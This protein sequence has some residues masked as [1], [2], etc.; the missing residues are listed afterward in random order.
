MNT[1]ITPPRMPII[2]AG[3]AIIRRILDLRFRASK[4]KAN[5]Q[6]ARATIAAAIFAGRIMMSP[7]LY[8][9]P[10]LGQRPRRNVYVR[11]APAPAQIPP[12]TPNFPT[13]VDAPMLWHIFCRF[14]WS[15]QTAVGRTVHLGRML[16]NVPS[17]QSSGRPS[18]E[19]TPAHRATQK[20]GNVGLIRPS[21][22]FRFAA[23]NGN[24]PTSE[25]FKA[26]S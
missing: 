17:S 9:T 1:E 12:P 22:R 6:N 25:F 7:F 10:E 24:D 19:A 11:I 4:T 8:V 5:E 16:R 3:Y 2:H 21:L 18:G 13:P 26:C 14:Q 20:L 15:P 23:L